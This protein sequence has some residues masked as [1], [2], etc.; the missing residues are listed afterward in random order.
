MA[1]SARNPCKSLLENFGGE[2]IYGKG[3]VEVSGR[4]E[5]PKLSNRP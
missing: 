5:G 1:C 2:L 3:W 4:Q